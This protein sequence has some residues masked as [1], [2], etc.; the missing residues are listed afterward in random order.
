MPMFNLAFIKSRI[1]YILALLPKLTLYKLYTITMAMIS[2]FMKRDR[3]S[4]APPL[5]IVNLTFRCN[6]S[7]IMC[8]KNA[9]GDNNP[10]KNPKSIDYETF[11][12]LLRENARYLSLV[13]L[14]GGEPMF[15]RE[16]DQ[17][18]DLLT[19]LD[20]PYTIITNGYLLTPEISKKLTKNCIQVSLSIDAVD[21]ELYQKMRRGGTIETVTS[22]IR[23]LN[24][25]KHQK[26]SKTPIL[27]ISS[28]FFGFNIGELPSLVRYCHENGIESLSAGEGW[29]YDTPYIGEEDLIHHHAVK[30]RTSIAEAQIL[31]E[32]LGII[33]RLKFPG[34]KTSQ[35][36]ES[37][38]GKK[39]ALKNRSC[40][41]LY[42]SAEIHPNLD[43][44][45]CCDAKVPFGNLRDVSLREVWN[46]PGYI[47]ARRKLRTHEVPEACRGCKSLY[48]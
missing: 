48:V 29:G 42:V 19:E 35:A 7:C 41:N 15:Y 9:P 28:T 33:L 18:I 27:N 11:A 25:I 5:L 14:H 45:A 32:E 6:Y 46:G 10:Y 38:P 39:P 4:T 40:M 23:N 31:A 24:E 47:D 21:S 37:V 12:R 1:H 22:N 26:G 3:S 43:V 17:L 34:L 44:I 13:R 30:A 20:I 36:G 2:F 16:F 8:Q